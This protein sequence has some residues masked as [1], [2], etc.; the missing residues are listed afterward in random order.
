MPVEPRRLLLTIDFAARQLAQDAKCL[1]R[2]HRVPDGS[3][4]CPEAK[5][6]FDAC[7]VH[8]FELRALAEKLAKAA[9]TKSERVARTFSVN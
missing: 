6:E 3:W 7:V 2:S 1:R 4:D 8:A 5:A 9:L